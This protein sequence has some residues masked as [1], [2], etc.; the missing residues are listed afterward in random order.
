M[1]C[2]CPPPKCHEGDLPICRRRSATVDTQRENSGRRAASRAK[3]SPAVRLI[4]AS[5]PRTLVVDLPRIVLSVSR[6][7]RLPNIIYAGHRPDPRGGRRPRRQKQLPRK[8]A[9]RIGCNS[10]R[11]FL[12]VFCAF[13]WQFFCL[14]I[15]NNI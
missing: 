3:S 5:S 11:V 10:L 7:L 1:G 12:C 9:K 6:V 15:L 13:L 4:E 8:N 14:E 2:G